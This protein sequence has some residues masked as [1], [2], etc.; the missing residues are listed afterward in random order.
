M[1]NNTTRNA[2][3]ASLA[4]D[5]ALTPDPR[6]MVPAW[7]ACTGLWDICDCAECEG[8]RAR[9]RELTASLAS[10]RIAAVYCACC[11]APLAYDVE[12][13]RVAQDVACNDVIKCGELQYTEIAHPE[14]APTWPVE[15]AGTGYRL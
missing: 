6:P 4:I 10:L 12:A 13:Q 2:A 8:F 7:E 5:E 14:C 11:S 3:S 15:K 9:E 1:L